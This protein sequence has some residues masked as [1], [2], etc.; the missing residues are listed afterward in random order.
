ME[1]KPFQLTKKRKIILASIGGIVCTVLIL[2]IFVLPAILTSKFFISTAKNIVLK[3]TG[4]NLEI[5]NPVIKTSLTP[6]IFISF[7]KLSITKEKEQLLDIDKFF[8]AFYFDPIFKKELKFKAL[9]VN[10]ISLDATKLAKIFPQ[11]QKRIATGL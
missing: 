11:Q 9:G 2:Y 1:N 10:K 4:A 6:K 5:V 3:T 8:T 7:D